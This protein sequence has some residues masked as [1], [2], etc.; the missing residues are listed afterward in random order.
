MCRPW[1]CHKTCAIGEDSGQAA[2]RHRQTRVLAGKLTLNKVQAV[3]RFRKVSTRIEP[4]SRGNKRPN[5]P[6][7]AAPPHTNDRIKYP[8]NVCQYV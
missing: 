1:R 6:A 2:L 4:R 5:A 8:D 7:Q 3:G